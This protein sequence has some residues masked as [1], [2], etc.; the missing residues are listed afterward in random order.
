MASELFKQYY[1]RLAKEGWLKALVCGAIAGFFAMLIAALTFWFVAVKLFWLSFVVLA[2]VTLG[3]MPIFYYVFF[4]PTSKD[5]ARRVDKLGL[6]ERLITMQQLMGDDSFIAMKQREDAQ[7]AITTV[8]AKMLKLVVSLPLIITMA[9]SGTFG[10][11]MTTVSALSAFGLLRD[12]KSFLDGDSENNGFYEVH[13]LA[14]GEGLVEGED[15]DEGGPDQIV[16]HGKHAAPVIAVPMEGWMFVE[17]SDGKTNPERHD[18]YIE[19]NLTVT[20]I[21]SEAQ[22]DE[23]FMQGGGDIEMDGLGDIPGRGGVPGLEDKP[24]A[25]SDVPNPGGA[26]VYEPNNQFINGNTYYGDKMYDDMY[27][28][29]QKEMEA[30]ENLSEDKKDI[31]NDYWDIIEK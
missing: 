9:I 13:Y 12:G 24:G 19:G 29:G 3:S 7:K 28:Q 30:N 14:Q 10:L 25:D 18:L 6:E 16:E 17:W 31:S 23:G 26:G 2:V 4:K 21:F 22:G 8:N 15:E 1:K 27:E 20:A 11:G 5:I